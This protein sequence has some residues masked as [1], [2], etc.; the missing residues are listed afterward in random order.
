MSAP[1]YETIKE[2]SNSGIRIAYHTVPGGYR[3]L[4]WHE[5]LELFY[6]LNGDSEIHVEGKKYR[7]MKKQLMVVESSQVHSTYCYDSTSMFICIHISK[8]HMQKYLPDIEQYRIDCCPERISVE[9]FPQY[10]E[11]CEKMETLTRIYIEDAPL[12]QMETEGIILQVLARLLRYFSVKDKA[13]PSKKE[14][15][16]KERI[17][18]IITYVD[19]HFREPISLSDIAS[20]IGLGNEY[21]CRFFKK[22][23][24]MSFSDYLNEVR[25]AHIYQDLIMTQDSISQI[26]EANGITNQKQF[27]RSFKALYG[28]TPSSIR[29][30]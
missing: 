29:K 7:L 20:Q 3:P 6:P 8:K 5:E 12:F 26:M 2:I 24:G 15:S 16:S 23:M 13:V 18:E 1:Y 19:T 28:C 27:N 4:H 9:A 25:L 11:I 10:R 22:Y 30:Q 21:F 17:R 14:L